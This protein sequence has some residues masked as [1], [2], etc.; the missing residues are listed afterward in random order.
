MKGGS[1]PSNT[2]ENTENKQDTSQEC[3]SQIIFGIDSPISPEE[4]YSPAST[5][6]VYIPSSSSSDTS[7]NEGRRERNE[8]QGK[9]QATSSVLQPKKR[10][11]FQLKEKISKKRTRNEAEWKQNR[12]SILKQEGKEYVTRQGKNMEGKNPRTG[13]LCKSTCRYKCYEIFCDIDCASLFSQYYTLKNNSEKNMFLSKFITAENVKRALTNPKRKRCTTYT[14]VL[15]KGGVNIKY[16]IARKLFAS[17]EHKFPEVGH[18]FLDCDR[19]FGRI[20]KLLRRHGK[21]FTPNQYRNIIK[22]ASKNNSIIE[23]MNHH[24]YDFIK[25]R[26]DLGIA[27]P[28]LNTLKQKINFKVNVKWIHVEDYGR[29]FYKTSYDPYTPFL[30]VSLLKKSSNIPEVFITCNNQKGK[31]SKEKIADIKTQLEYIEKES[32]WYYINILNNY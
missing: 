11:I 4:P 9:A 6:D 14:Y 1:V 12:N 21:I 2:N 24:F 19:D 17:I 7:E 30:E 25:L 32:Q 18:T 31:I 3:D 26:D 20:E 15:P 16:M 8:I 29:Y 10:K 5:D 27:I 28:N 22:K 23:D 13:I